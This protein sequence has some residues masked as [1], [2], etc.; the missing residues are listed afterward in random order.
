M[1][2]IQYHRLP[3]SN[4]DLI[5]RGISFKWWGGENTGE[6]VCELRSKIAKG[7]VVSTGNENSETLTN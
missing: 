2:S 7:V 5:F 3:S 4:W 6:I 1:L